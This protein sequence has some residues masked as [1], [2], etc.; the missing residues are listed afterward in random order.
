MAKNG[1]LSTLT[2]RFHVL[3][4]QRIA[5][6]DDTD[7]VASL[8]QRRNKVVLARFAPMIRFLPTSTVSLCLNLIRRSVFF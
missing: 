4:V 5:Q 6:A 1:L 3:P 8:L 7:P 2:T